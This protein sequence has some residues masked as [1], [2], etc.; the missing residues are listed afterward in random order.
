M[1]KT[2]L[3]KIFVRLVAFAIFAI[4]LSTS[5]NSTLIKPEKTKKVTSSPPVVAGFNQNYYEWIDEFEN[6]QLI[7]SSGGKSYNYKVENGIVKIKHTCSVWTDPDWSRMKPITVTNNGGETFYDFAVNFIIDY[8]TDMQSDYDDIRFKHQNTPTN[9]LDY[10]IED[11]DS[12]EVS[13]WVRV[14]ELTQ[15]TNNMYLF[16]GN[17]SANDE[18]DF[19]AVFTGWE[20]LWANDVL[21]SYHGD[22]EGAWDPD[23]SFDGDD[24][25]IVTWEEGQAYWFPLNMGFKQEIRASI[26]QVDDDS[27][28]PV[29]FDKR[30]FSDSEQENGGW[31]FYRNED[32]S[33][34][35]GGGKWFIAWEHWAP[36]NTPYNPQ[37]ITTMNIKARTI[38]KSGNGISR[39]NVINVCTANGCQAD[40][41]VVFDSENDHFLVIWEDGRDSTS[42]YEIYGQLYD[43][44]G[45]TVGSEKELNG[46]ANSQCEPRAAFDPINEQFFVVWEEGITPNN[47]PFRIRGGIFD[48][49]LNTIWT[50]TIAE[51]NNYPND[52][53][54]YNF[55][56]VCFDEES[57]RYLVTW[58]DCDISDG[59]WRGNIYGKIYDTSGNIKVNK[60]TIKN[61]NY[62]R[63]EIVPYLSKSFFVSF[64]NG[65]DIYG[66]IVSFEGDLIG[67]DVQ[68]SASPGAQADWASIDTDGSEIFVAWEDIRF[69]YPDPFDSLY[70]DSMGNSWN[71][72]IPD[73]NDIQ[74]A[75]G[76]EQQLTL[77]AQITSIEIDPENL[78]KWHEFRETSDGTITFDIL[79]ENCN[80]IPGYE[81][82]SSGQ[83]ISAISTSQYPCI[84]LR[85]HFTRTNP[86]YSPLL[87]N[88]SVLY[89]GLDLEPPITWLKDIDGTPGWNDWYTS[90][91]VFV[92]LEA[93]DFPE[94][95]GSGVNVTYYTVNGG[96]AQIYDD[97]GGINLSSQPPDWWNIYLVNFWSV[98]NAGNP[99]Q[100]NKP[101]NTI[102]IKIDSEAP[103]VIITEP[104]Q[105][106][107]VETPFW[108]YA[109][110]TEN[111]E[112]D[113]VRFDME[114]WEQR[115]KLP[116]DDYTPPW[117][118]FCEQRPL[119]RTK[120]IP[121][122]PLAGRGEQIE[123]RAWPYDKAHHPKSEPYTIWIEITNWKKA[124]VVTVPNFKTLVGLF[125]L[126]VARNDKLSIKITGLLDVDAVK[127]VA[128]KI[129]TRG[130]TTIWDN[131]FSDGF[132]ADFNI[133]T[134]FY[135]ITAYSYLEEK[136]VGQ[137]TLLRVF[138]IDR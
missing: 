59:D 37:P 87:Y 25:F 118:W 66:K 15:G 43:T 119:A 17:P 106:E 11:Y 47:G 109:E 9:F 113:Y 48:E 8:D 3:N 115:P 103:I 18:S 26:Y 4:L 19:G 125:N 107:K 126:G 7:D 39:G 73:G 38:Q 102:T 111:A 78:E 68:M 31:T 130:Q 58:N 89:E 132:N 80:I 112:M 114:P 131:D 2:N 41:L 6:E 137:E 34:A 123:I 56:A 23:V 95:T 5:V 86:S 1:K 136:E 133:P 84:R 65:N 46:D 105:G 83:D 129:F 49:N 12:S 30:V 93:K 50:G 70:P 85:A 110:V 99:E 10:W 42:D 97:D 71:L 69:P 63:T 35:R 64:D 40:P 128:T 104:G 108:V 81:D 29:V 121:R 62:V 61:G 138:Y 91:S 55:P 22:Y 54:D 24:K 117:R 135:K 120:A 77:D 16:Y 127:F 72:S 32:P 79:D 76:D 28:P 52:D 96:P 60:F 116:F 74:Y 88:W 94:Q 53:V 98:D 122:A 44:N 134:G 14:P 92:Y 20:E 36:T 51:P 45:N 124:K 101:E 13:V 82:V 67:G 27:H 90:V 33:I 100:P 57:E 21:F 75:L